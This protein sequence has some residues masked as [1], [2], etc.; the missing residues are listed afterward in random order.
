MKKTILSK[1]ATTV[2]H[3]VF[4]DKPSMYLPLN[5]KFPIV[6]NYEIKKWW[7]EVES[8]FYLEDTSDW[9]QETVSKAIKI[10]EVEMG[11]IDFLKDCNKFD[12]FLKLKSS[13]KADLLND[14]LN[15]NCMTFNCLN[16]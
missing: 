6:E 4:E 10:H 9:F 5:G 16:I 14:F 13:E 7:K 2:S 1:I 12:T 3:Y 11:F 8:T 15:K